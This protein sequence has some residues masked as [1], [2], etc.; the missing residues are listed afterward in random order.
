M[1]PARSV[2]KE[3]S[4]SDADT[5]ITEVSS[6][7][8][9]YRDV[10]VQQLREGRQPRQVVFES[11]DHNFDRAL[12]WGFRKRRRQLQTLDTRYNGR[13]PPRCESDSSRQ[14]PEQRQ[15][16]QRNKD[17]STAKCESET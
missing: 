7:L 3:N 12:R 17:S 4:Q 5:A 9:V 16:Q 11:G 15:R 8:A 14:E 2:C 13:I 10:C 1:T 6:H